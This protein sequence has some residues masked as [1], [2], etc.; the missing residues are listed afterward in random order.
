MAIVQHNG[1]VFSTGAGANL[2]R[3]ANAGQTWQSYGLS[4]TLAGLAFNTRQFVAHGNTLYAA[5]LYRI[6]KTE[7]NG[8]TW[9]Q[10]VRLHSFNLTNWNP[11]SQ[12][13]A[14]DTALLFNAK[15]I[16]YRYRFSTGTWD[17]S[18][19]PNDI[20][21]KALVIERTASGIWVATE[22]GAIYKSEDE[23]LTWAFVSNA[24]GGINAA[25][26]IGDTLI[27]SSPY[28]G[29]TSRLSRSFDGG[30]T[31]ELRFTKRLHYPTFKYFQGK[32]Y[33]LPQSDS[34]KVLVSN[35]LGETWTTFLQAATAPP[36]SDLT[37]LPNGTALAAEKRGI[38]KTEDSG[39][40][41]QYSN[42]GFSSGALLEGR[43]GL[44]WSVG[45]GLNH[46]S[47]DG[48]LQWQ[49]PFL[50]DYIFNLPNYNLY[51]SGFGDVRQYQGKWY[52]TAPIPVTPPQGYGLYISDGD[53]SRWTFQPISGISTFARLLAAGNFLLTYNEQSCYYRYSIDGGLTFLY[54]PNYAQHGTCAEITEHKDHFFGLDGTPGKVLSIDTLKLDD[55]FQFKWDT[56]GN[57]LPAVVFTDFAVSEDRL[58]VFSAEKIAVS[59]D[60]GLHWSDITGN[61]P[62]A[63]SGIQ[64]VALAGDTIM[65]V[66]DQ[67]VL[68]SLGASGGWTD[69]T[70]DLAEI[71]QKAISDEQHFVVRGQQGGLFRINLDNL[72]SIHL[73]GL[74]F[75]DENQN[76]LLDAGENGLANALIQI[77]KTGFLTTDAAGEFDYQTF[78]TDSIR[79]IL[80]T[81]YATITPAVW[82]LPAQ[83]N[84]NQQFAVQFQNN[85]HDLA[86]TLTRATDYR[87]GFENKIFATVRNRGTVATSGEVRVLV[88]EQLDF[89]SANPAPAANIGD[90]ILIWQTGDLPLFGSWQAAISV[91]TKTVGTLGNYAQDTG[92]VTIIATDAFPED[93]F[94]SEASLI[95]GSFDPNDK[96]VSPAVL[97][98]AMLPQRPPITYTIR[99]QNTG[100][101][102]ATHVRILDTLALNFDASALQIL[103]SS[104]PMTWQLNGRV[105]T[106]LFENIQLPDSIADE[107]GSHGFVQFSL[108]PGQSVQTG[109]VLRNQAAIYFDFNEPIFTAYAELPVQKTVVTREIFL[110]LCSNQTPYEG[111]YY[112]TDTTLIK[113]LPGEL[114][115]TQ[116]IVHLNWYPYIPATQIQVET[117]PGDTLFGHVWSTPG[118]DIIYRTETSINGCDSLLQYFV[119]INWD[120]HP[121]M[122]QTLHVG[123]SVF[124]IP[125]YSDT[126]LIFPG[127]TQKGCDSTLTVYVSVL[128]ASESPDSELFTLR[129]LPNP[130]SGFTRL[131]FQNP[132]AAVLDIWLESLDGRLMRRFA[133]QQSFPAGQNELRLGLDGLPPGRWTVAIREKEGQIYRVVLVTM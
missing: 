80:P 6:F 37:V 92:F 81:P 9:S 33:A 28:L 38:L 91:R 100:T 58:V 129:I 40:H 54:G 23:G 14:T 118:N 47:T 127:V 75:N 56:L 53:L 36:I 15:G 11:G 79:V 50:T 126:V 97:S 51:A 31:W 93:N 62:T 125:C 42:V 27:A 16:V 57:G 94:F 63:G 84:A 82:Y 121:I 19:V 59:A 60:A 104:H 107:P 49:T 24:P 34:T 46:F 26:F 103:A 131:V 108:R 120:F 61:L 20:T 29:D 25:I 55:E 65:A 85:V 41:W 101:S 133:H 117:C 32:L 45:N 72:Q 21:G 96:V 87:P 1:Y 130:A 105:L 22:Y 13:V 114:V 2:Y 122:Q 98:S 123:D 76:N 99:F 113:I 83:A 12:L 77:G 70:G 10:V 3:S 124:G 78:F 88:A 102:A 52:A 68:V 4:D 119:Q 39:Q 111:V 17:Q 106:F 5:G 132:K 110:T 7:D 48:G 73:Q 90:S 71:P 8:D 74:V 43:E 44:L 112:P 30:Q 115:D 18:F 109:E 116:R 67:R 69:I 128:T 86:L 64:S 95:R 66:T 89:L 35:D